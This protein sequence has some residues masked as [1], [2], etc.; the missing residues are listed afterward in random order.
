MRRTRVIAITL[1]AVMSLSGCAKMT[2]ED[3]TKLPL[4]TALSEKE[5]IDYYAKS[6][7]YDTIVSKNLTVDKI[8]YET[9]EVT[10]KEKIDQ[11][12]DMI[13]RAEKALGEKEYKYTVELGKALDENT[14]HYIKSMLN[15]KTLNNSNIVT[16]EEAIGHYFVEVEYDIS[17]APIGNFT[18][19]ISLMGI[20]GAF[21][22]DY[23][24]EDN[25]DGTFVRKAVADL[26]RHYEE[27][28]TN[29]TASFGES[30]GIL[31]ITGD[32][33][34]YDLVF[35]VDYSEPQPEKP[36]ETKEEVEGDEG[37]GGA[38]VETPETDEPVDDYEVIANPTDGR[39]KS[40]V[41]TRHPI[42]DIQEFNEIVG[43]S[44]KETAYVPDLPLIYNIP[45][46]NG[47]ISGVGLYPVGNGGFTKFKFNRDT[48]VG[49]LTMKYVYKD[50][51]Y[52][53][54]NLI[55]I[56]IYPLNLS[57][58]SGIGEMIV[59]TDGALVM[60]E[61]LQEE[62][63]KLL[64]RAD[65]AT[66]NN[67]IPALMNGKIYSD[68]GMVA[69]VG[70][71]SG[72][73]NLLR[74]MTKFK[75]LITREP[76]QNTYIIEVEQLR[77]EGPKGA[78]V[79][80]TYIETAYVTI[81]QDTQDFIITDWY[82][83]DREIKVEP[84]INP[85]NAIT[86]RLVA[87]NLAGPIEDDQKVEIQTLMGN[88]YTASTNRILR[89]P[90]EVNKVTIEKGMYDCFNDDVSMLSSAR[91]EYINSEMREQLVKHGVNVSA[92]MSGVVTS[93]IGGADK[94]AEFTTEEIITYKGRKSGRKFEVYYLVSKIKD[95]WVIDERTIL[96]SSEIS[97][98][99]LENAISRIRD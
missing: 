63:E 57:M 2:R 21:Y 49:K 15:D 30:D 42:V 68:I 1:L 35:D 99:E 58:Q 31:Q 22:K 24:K 89:G 7:S 6:L 3:V 56:N 65:R 88:L 96:D 69:L 66:L 81:E 80:A 59:D 27:S 91:K 87:L 29:R 20:H 38:E 34:E 95:E 8:N 76:E 10:R 28:R 61:F 92:E 55:P 79:Y 23:K 67:D 17:N 77:Q 98:E 18:N 44:I 93:W 40:N 78:D 46:P 12:T 70:Y 11:I 60:P 72:Y 86:K 13:S 14:F 71:E 94:Q 62:I 83:V 39:I 4:E 43:S 37:V 48:M 5:V 85:D 97:G 25:I 41:N 45:E 82:T 26:N 74:Q 64:E 47:L 52:N 54:G 33:T 90:H 50:D 32:G 9:R 84:D 16:I 73:V 19:N 75:R 53:P 36:V 51:I